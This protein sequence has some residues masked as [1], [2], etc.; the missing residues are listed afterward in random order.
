MNPKTN[1]IKSSKSTRVYVNLGLC[2]LATS[3]NNSDSTRNL[4]KTE[5]LAQEQPI[6]SKHKNLQNQSQNLMILTS[7]NHN[8]TSFN[9][10]FNKKKISKL[11]H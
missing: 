3:K 8:L 2:Y 5:T 6:S 10:H 7:N 11:K 9:F 1:N 4:L